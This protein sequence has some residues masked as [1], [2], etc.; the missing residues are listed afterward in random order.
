[1]AFSTL[2][3]ALHPRSDLELNSPKKCIVATF[4]AMLFRLRQALNRMVQ[5]K[6]GR[7]SLN[8]HSGLPKES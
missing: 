1:M 4:L 6:F 8:Q 5:G 2:P 3:K 7:Y